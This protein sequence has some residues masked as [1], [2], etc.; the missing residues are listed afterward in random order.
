MAGNY[1][2]Y[3]K[4]LPKI[5]YGPRLEKDYKGSRK[6]VYNI[7]RIGF[8]KT[9]PETHKLACGMNGIS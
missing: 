7:P 2:G 5:E 6:G 8:Y 9:M 4:I 3:N 1:K